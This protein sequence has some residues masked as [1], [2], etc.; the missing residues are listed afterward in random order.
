ML[1]PSQPSPELTTSRVQKKGR[2]G[3]NKEEPKKIVL[4]GWGLIASLYIYFSFFLGPLNKTRRSMQ[5]QLDEVQAKLASSQTEI[6]RVAKL[7]ESA[8][9]ATARHEALR[10]LSPDGAPI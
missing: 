9:T 4:G 7:E 5:A 3:M 6:G 1:R 2:A 8:R 10:S